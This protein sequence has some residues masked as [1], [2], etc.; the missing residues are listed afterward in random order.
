MSAMLRSTTDSSPVSASH[1]STGCA[2]AL[3]RAASAASRRV[4]A[5]AGSFCSAQFSAA[6]RSAS[7]TS[8]F[9][10]SA[11]RDSSLR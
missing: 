3:S 11:W 4:R 8:P 2:A 7:G 10:A 5:S 6:R 1:C 9:S